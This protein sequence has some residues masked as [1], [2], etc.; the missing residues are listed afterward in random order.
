MI[1]QLALLKTLVDQDCSLPINEDLISTLRYVSCEGGLGADPWPTFT[2]SREYHMERLLT[3]FWFGG[4]LLKPDYFQMPIADID[5]LL[6]LLA[7]NYNSVAEDIRGR[8][9]I[10]DPELSD[11]VEVL[12]SLLATIGGGMATFQ[13]A[14][15][16]RKMRG[17]LESRTLQT[18][19]SMEDRAAKYPGF[20]A[21]YRKSLFESLPP[22]FRFINRIDL[23]VIEGV[24]P[25]PDG[26][27][28]NRIHG[29]YFP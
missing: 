15:D 6:R 29:E 7:D 1:H 2:G 16:L 14:V 9:R 8:R 26:S 12:D 17:E 18:P 22:I 19:I 13:L 10:A 21:C 28:G 25:G 23:M 3:I 11:D 20:T 5:R 27:V 24:R 4:Y